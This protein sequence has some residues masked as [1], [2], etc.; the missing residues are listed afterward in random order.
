MSILVGGDLMGYSWSGTLAA[1]GV[2]AIFDRCAALRLSGLL[3]LTDGGRRA[4]VVFVGGEAIETRGAT[5]DEAQAFRGGFHLT[6]RVPDL[7]GALTAGIRCEGELARSPAREV[8]RHC[9][10]ALLT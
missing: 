6:Q 3:E 1:T 8:I 2:R 9:Q 5:D 10:D 4:Q 7:S